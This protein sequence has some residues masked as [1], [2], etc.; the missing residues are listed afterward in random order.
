LNGGFASAI[1]AARPHAF[2]I[3]IAAFKKRKTLAEM[4]PFAQDYLP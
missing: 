4:Q 1:G 3:W 2:D